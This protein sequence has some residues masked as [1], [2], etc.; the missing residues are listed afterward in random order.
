MA[1]K[2]VTHPEGKFLCSISKKIQ[3]LDIGKFLSLF[4]LLVIEEDI[5]QID[6]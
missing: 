2:H 5:E 6:L 4:S 1:H 3:P